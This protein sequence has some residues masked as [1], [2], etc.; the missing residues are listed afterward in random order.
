M[1]NNIKYLKPNTLGIQVVDGFWTLSIYEFN[2][3][4]SFIVTNNIVGDR[5]NIQTFN[6]IN[7]KITPLK[8]INWFGGFEY[9]LLINN[10]TDCIELL[11]NNLVSYNYNFSDKDIVEISGALNKEESENCF[12]GNTIKY[13]LNKKDRTFDIVDVY[14]KND[15]YLSFNKIINEIKADESA[16]VQDNDEF[17][18]FIFFRSFQFCDNSNAAFTSEEAEIVYLNKEINLDFTKIKSLLDWN[19]FFYKGAKQC[20][21]D[22]LGEK[23]NSSYLFSTNEDFPFDNIVV[24]ND[25]HIITAQDGFFFVFKKYRESDLVNEKSTIKGREHLNL[26]KNSLTPI[27]Q[28]IEEYETISL[29]IKFSYDF[30]IELKD[31]STIEETLD[32]TEFDHLTDFQFAKL[33]SLGKTRLL[34]VSG[35]MESGQSELY[36]LTLNDTLNIIDNIMLYTHKETESGGI[37]TKFKISKDFMISV[38]K[39][40]EIEGSILI[41][42]KKW[43]KI[44]IAGKI[45]AAANKI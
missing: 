44:D 23:N 43:F 40:E 8:M 36:L 17:E 16:V 7:N 5:N 29:P 11:E 15:K 6:F 14:W 9:K 45:K 1:Y 21:E 39:E 26:S 2:E 3:N 33:P 37:T 35:F 18:N 19:S 13:K 34:L 22:E 25:R 10:T 31:F 12:K 32:I 24:F 30:A 28:A 41:L 20:I 4:H 27:L 38:L 42:E